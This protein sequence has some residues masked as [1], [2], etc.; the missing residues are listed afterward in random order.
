MKEILIVD[1]NL[2]ED[3]RIEFLYDYSKYLIKHKC[4][5]EKV[6]N[7]MVENSHLLKHMGLDFNFIK[8]VRLVIILEI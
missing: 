1:Y 8:K 3:K 5:D 4:Y 2:E 7:W 6:L